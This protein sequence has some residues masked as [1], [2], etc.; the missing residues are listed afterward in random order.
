MGFMPVKTGL[1]F[2]PMVGAMM[3][4]TILATN[5]LVPKIGPVPVMPAGMAIGSLGLLRMTT[6]GVDSSTP[7]MSCHSSS[8]PDSAWASSWP[9]S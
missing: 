6:L 8:S 7:R 9:P 5:F 3:T 2:L 4:G 1:A